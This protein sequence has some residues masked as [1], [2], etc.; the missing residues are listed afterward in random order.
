MITQVSLFSWENV[1]PFYRPS[2][3]L[4]KQLARELDLTT[5]LPLQAYVLF[6]QHVVEMQRFLI[7]PTLKK[8]ECG[9]HL[10]L[11]GGKGFN[12]FSWTKFDLLSEMK[13]QNSFL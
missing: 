3:V 4:R 12:L 2:S 7:H 6:V 9:N 1:P 11:R 5:L 10:Y 8:P 13:L